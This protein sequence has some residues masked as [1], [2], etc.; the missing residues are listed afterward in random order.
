MSL[1]KIKEYFGVSNNS[2][3]S[4]SNRKYGN[5]ERMKRMDDLDVGECSESLKVSENSF[6]DGDHRINASDLDGFLHQAYDYFFHKGIR[7]VT[8][9]I[10]L[11]LVSTF[12]VIH[13]I[14]FLSF[15]DWNLIF[16]QCEAHTEKDHNLNKDFYDDCDLLISIYSHFNYV[17]TILKVSVTSFIYW[18]LIAYFLKLTLANLDYFSKMKYMSHVYQTIIKIPDDELENLTFNH[19][20]NQLINLQHHTQF[21]KVKEHLTK[22]DIISR[23][24]RKNNYINMLL[25]RE[26]IDFDIQMHIPLQGNRWFRLFKTNL[27]TQY[28]HRFLENCVTNLA[29]ENGSSEILKAFLDQ[30]MLLKRSIFKHTIIGCIFTIPYLVMK[31]TLFLIRN[32]ESFSSK[33]TNS[34][35]QQSKSSFLSEKG[36][37]Y[38]QMCLFKCYNELDDQFD[39]RIYAGT[40]ETE[41]FTNKFGLQFSTI[42][43][44]FLSFVSGALLFSIIIISVLDETM[45]S[46]LRI[47]GFNLLYIAVSLGF[48][49]GYSKSNMLPSVHGR[50]RDYILDPVESKIKLYI[51]LVGHLINVPMKWTDK[52]LFSDKHNKIKKTYGMTLFY[53]IKEL[54]SIILLPIIAYKL[55]R[56]VD[57][58]ISYFNK[59]TIRVQGLGDICSFSACEIEPEEGIDI[60]SNNNDSSTESTGNWSVIMKNSL[61]GLFPTYEENYWFNFRKQLYSVI[62]YYVGC[63][64]LIFN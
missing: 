49:L 34:S 45:L 59:Y 6:D 35:S 51:S 30:K 46:K 13:L 29:F 23:I 39:I 53:F 57:I 63:V 43:F 18:L 52:D 9:K 10:I 27:M 19:I 4:R 44:N 41:T 54:L 8:L 11:D 58:I 48:L 50:V 20:I 56:K 5:H 36:F 42:I 24:S 14:F 32:A 7:N 64:Y 17:G 3:T 21:C 22:F 60:V 33:S 55:Y 61:F 25:S 38:H 37:S 15:I 26:V 47:Y 12:F 1:S 2:N 31:I 28:T 40:Q 62:L 16:R